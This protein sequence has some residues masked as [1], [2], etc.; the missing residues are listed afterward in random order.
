MLKDERVSS[1]CSVMRQKSS[2]VQNCIVDSRLVM[3]VTDLPNGQRGIYIHPEL[4]TPL[5]MWACPDKWCLVSRVVALYQTELVTEHLMREAALSSESARSAMRERDA[6]ALR[7]R[8]EVRAHKADME[9]VISE[10]HDLASRL[11]ETEHSLER[12][13]DELEELDDE[14][15]DD[16]EEK[17]DLKEKVRVLESAIMSGTTAR[18]LHAPPPCRDMYTLGPHGET[19]IDGLTSEERDAHVILYSITSPYNGTVFHASTG[20]RHKVT[21]DIKVAKYAGWWFSPSSLLMTREQWDALYER[22]MREGHA[23]DLDPEV[24]GQMGFRLGDGYTRERLDAEC[25]EAS[26]TRGR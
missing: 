22:L 21:G 18:L 23:V 10:N 6:S 17:W 20:T 11:E 26:G 5:A 14:V 2:T 4:V 1:H 7:W 8:R 9:R 19:L 16:D 12:A 3:N 25:L 13:R 24:P 15:M